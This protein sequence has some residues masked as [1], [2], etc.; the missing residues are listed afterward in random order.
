MAKAYMVF[1]PGE[2]NKLVYYVMVNKT[3]YSVYTRSITYL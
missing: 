1:Q 3:M 2:L